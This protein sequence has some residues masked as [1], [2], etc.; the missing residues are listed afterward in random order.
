[1]PRGVPLQQPCQPHE[2]AVTLTRLPPM[3]GLRRRA[4]LLPNGVQLQYVCMGTT[5]K[6]RRR[7]G[8]PCNK[9]S[10]LT[11]TH[12][13]DRDSNIERNWKTDR[14]PGTVWRS[15]GPCMLPRVVDPKGGMEI[16]AGTKGQ[17]PR[18]HAS[19]RRACHP[20]R[21]G[22]TVVATASLGTLSRLM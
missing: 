22:A 4:V 1:M 16:P 15:N 2:L 21:H 18:S 20:M 10:K 12:A 11:P 5:Q 9:M 3:T 13:S 7:L 14:C 19:W 6:G 17:N 8:F